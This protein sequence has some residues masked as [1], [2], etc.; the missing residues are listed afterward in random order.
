MDKQER[1]ELVNAMAPVAVKEFTLN[2]EVVAYGYQ[3]LV[4]GCGAH[5]DYD[6]NAEAVRAAKRHSK[7][8]NNL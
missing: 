5:R 8:H 4:N 1:A 6:T 3:C 7:R 2:G